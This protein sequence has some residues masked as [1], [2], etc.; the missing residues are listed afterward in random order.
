LTLGRGRGVRIGLGA[1]L[2][3]CGCNHR[4]AVRNLHGYATS[5]QPSA[6]EV[7]VVLG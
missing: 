3:S 5:I 1:L 2:L 6:V 4:L 7:S